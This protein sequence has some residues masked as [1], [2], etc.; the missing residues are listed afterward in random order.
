MNFETGI[1]N[2]QLVSGGLALDTG[3]E[4]PRTIRAFAAAMVV[5]S[6]GLARFFSAEISGTGRNR[7]HSLYQLLKFSRWIDNVV[8]R[9]YDPA[10][11][12]TY[13]P[14]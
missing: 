12:V 7:P 3:G 10:D 9:G 2:F 14:C 4:S 13:S 1:V 11:Q 8:G 5:I 6:F